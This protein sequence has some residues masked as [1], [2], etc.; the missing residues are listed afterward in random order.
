M[1]TLVVA[2]FTA[3]SLVPARAQTPQFHV[4]TAAEAAAINA[5]RPSDW[6]PHHLVAGDVFVIDRDGIHIPT[7]AVVP[8]PTLYGIESGLIPTWP[9]AAVS[10][11]TI[12][13][14]GSGYSSNPTAAFLGGV[15]HG[16]GA[17]GT[18]TLT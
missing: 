17:G 10:G 14:G 1:R 5:R 3:V 16:G 6:S 11:C 2:I 8:S 13:S 7:S 9:T 4:L 15:T 12:V 18:I